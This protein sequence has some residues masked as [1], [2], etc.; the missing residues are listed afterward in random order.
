MLFLTSCHHPQPIYCVSELQGLA[1]GHSGALR[2][3]CN[4]QLRERRASFIL[5]ALSVVHSLPYQG[6]H[7][8]N[9]RAVAECKGCNICALN[10]KRPRVVICH[11]VAAGCTSRTG[12]WN[13]WWSPEGPSPLVLPPGHHIHLHLTATLPWPVAPA[14]SSLLHVATTEGS[15]S[16]SVHYSRFWEENKSQEYPSLPFLS[17]HSDKLTALLFCK[18]VPVS[19]GC[20]VWKSVSKTLRNLFVS[21]DCACLN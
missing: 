9:A 20:K 21:L 1:G 6:F 19:A 10:E 5:F 11:A 17:K 3:C 12:S 18:R 8:E 14:G 2:V 16:T 15:P 7:P 13:I 4:I